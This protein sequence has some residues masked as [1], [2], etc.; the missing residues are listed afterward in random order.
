MSCTNILLWESVGHDV[1]TLRTDESPRGSVT[2]VRG[3]CGGTSQFGI[4]SWAPSQNVTGTARKMGQKG[5]LTVP[6]VGL[7]SRN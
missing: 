1:M 4:V 5:Q 2:L 7:E 6:P 3:A